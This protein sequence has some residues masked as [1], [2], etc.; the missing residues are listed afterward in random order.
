MEVILNSQNFEGE[1]VKSDIPVL[2]DFWAQW[3][4]PCHVIAPS[5]SQIA[6]EYEGKLKI[7]KLNV[8]ENPGIAEKYLVRSI[9][10]LKLFM[11][12]QVADE[13][14]GAVPKNV[15]TKLVEKH[16]S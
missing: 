1:V 2:V 11:K 14:V 5:V 13:I 12:G 16:L 10:N 4:G 15:I 9:P 7:G 6:Q 8:D 3:C